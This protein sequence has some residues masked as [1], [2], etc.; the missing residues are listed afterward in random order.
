MKLGI[1]LA[2]IYA[3][4]NLTACNTGSN[5]SAPE[6]TAPTSNTEQNT[7]NAN[8]NTNTSETPNEG[9]Y[10]FTETIVVDDKPKNFMV[11]ILPNEGEG[12]SLTNAVAVATRVLG[13]GAAG[14]G[15]QGL[16]SAGT[17]AARGTARDICKDA[18][19]CLVFVKQ[20]DDLVSSGTRNN[21]PGF[22]TAARAE[23]VRFDAL[24]EW[25]K[26]ARKDELSKQLNEVPDSGIFMVK[27]R[28]HDGSIREKP[29]VGVLS[30]DPY[31]NYYVAV[32]TS[33]SSRFS[34]RRFC[35]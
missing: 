14:A 34:C 33:F 17:R 20:N 16:A 13:R 31:G 5:N 25:I 26:G 7:K 4:L 35:S 18:R 12:L 9:E 29:F 15:A 27:E 10:L 8:A 21:P 2:L 24:P 19:N 3:V 32:H 23:P 30:Q 6:Q 28:L 22:A 1:T 11:P